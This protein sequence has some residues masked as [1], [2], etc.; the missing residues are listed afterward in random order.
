MTVCAGPNCFNRQYPGEGGTRNGDGWLC[1]RCS[2]NGQAEVESVGRGGG[3]GR[4]LGRGLG[5]G[6]PP[7]SD[8]SSSHSEA[9]PLVEWRLRKDAHHD[10]DLPASVQGVAGFFAKVYSLRLEGGDERPVPFAC[11]WVAN[12]LGMSRMTVWRALRILEAEGLIKKMDPLPG[13]G[14][15]GV[16]TYLPGDGAS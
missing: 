10:L 11:E 3:V 9:P 8:S 15:K 7:T 1:E 6:P 4:G 12:H 13:R 14:K 16:D 5:L 2:P